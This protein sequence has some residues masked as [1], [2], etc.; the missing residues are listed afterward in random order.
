MIGTTP[1]DD[2]LAA[3]PVIP[4]LGH[5]LGN[6]FSAKLKSLLSGISGGTEIFLRIEGSVC[7]SPEGDDTRPE[8]KLLLVRQRFCEPN[9]SL[10]GWLA[11]RSIQG[12]IDLRN[13]QVAAAPRQ[14]ASQAKQP[15]GQPHD[16][17]SRFFRLM[18]VCP[19]SPRMQLR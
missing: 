3:G 15:V 19:Q 12:V 17:C 5:L 18:T 6:D 13:G 2:D 7:S 1:P 9:A 11:N 10:P 14:A 4:Q 16:Y 8:R